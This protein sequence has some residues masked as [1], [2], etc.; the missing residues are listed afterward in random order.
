M[1]VPSSASEPSLL[2]VPT[3]K[4]ELQF[5]SAYHFQGVSLNWGACQYGMS[6]YIE[7]EST[8]VNRSEPAV[9]SVPSIA[10]ELID[11]SVPYSLNE[12][13]KGN[14]STPTE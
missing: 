7:R 1:C 6:E 5:T 12:P 8:H 4:S 9:K 2:C 11:G 13:N 10:S 3:C 14:V